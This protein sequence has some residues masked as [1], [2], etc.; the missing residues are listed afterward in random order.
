LKLA[1]TSTGLQVFKEQFNDDLAFQ[2]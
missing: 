2:S 1:V